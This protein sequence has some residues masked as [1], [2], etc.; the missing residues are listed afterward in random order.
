MEYSEKL[1]HQYKEE[2]E[3]WDWAGIRK[4]AIENCVVD[5]YELKFD[6][7][8]IASCWLGT[9]FA[10]MPSG[11]YYMPWTTNQTAKDVI[12]GQ[13]Y[14][15]ALEEVAESNGMY[16]SSGEG[17]PC[18]L[19]AQFTIDGSDYNELKDEI[20]FVCDEYERD[21]LAAKEIYDNS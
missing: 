19:Y 18:D 13:A 17:D 12:R 5:S 7:H 21:F 6:L 2:V 1:Y 16:I 9:V 10:I 20:I 4:S 11:K 15:Q 8:I 3:F 14:W